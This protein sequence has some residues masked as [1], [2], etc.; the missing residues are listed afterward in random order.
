MFDFRIANF[1]DDVILRQQ[2]LVICYNIGRKFSE[3]SLQESRAV[4]RKPRDAAAVLFGLK[5]VDNTHNK[6]KSRQASKDM[7]QS[8]KHTAAEQNLA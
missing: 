8:S 6:F 1:L 3:F 7:L 2:Y 4:A 5:F